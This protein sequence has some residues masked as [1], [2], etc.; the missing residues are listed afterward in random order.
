M[1][2]LHTKLI[3]YRRSIYTIFSQKRLI[4]IYGIS[5]V[6]LTCIWWFFTEIAVMVGNYGYTHTVFDIMLSIVTILFFPLFLIALWHRGKVL[7]TNPQEKKTSGIIGIFWG[8]LST[9]ISGSSCCGLTLAIYFGLMPLMNLLPYDG[10]ELKTL[11]LIGLIYGLDQILTYLESCL[12]K[13]V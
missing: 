8:I 3:T 10:L 7:K 13:K 6:L 11:G 4:T 5:V 9:I 12:V 1:N 2:F